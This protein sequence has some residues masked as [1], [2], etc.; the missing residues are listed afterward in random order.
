M[1][2]IPRKKSPRAPSLPLNEALERAIK[3]YDRE[4]LHP[5]TTDIIAQHLGYKSANNGSALSILASLRYFGLLDRP[6]EGML[7]VAK[8]VESYKFAPDA[9]L[10]RSLLLGFL[11]RPALYSDL[12]EKY[13]SG[14]PSDANLKY[15]L[16]QRGFA[17]QAAESALTVFKGS[18]GFANYFG[19]ESD[20]EFEGDTGDDFQDPITEP[21]E[22]Q[23]VAENVVPAISSLPLPNKISQEDADLD[24]I[25]VRLPGGRRAWL[26]IP[27]PFYN[28]DKARLKAQIDLLLTLEDEEG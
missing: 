6:K 19:S 27:T 1:T 10:R 17:P 20:N 9:N 5:A 18:V 16:I 8:E 11:G 22:A 24:R 15:E 23:P 26:L 3:I 4:R 28:A 12:L 2:G 7:S 25:P 13:A 14:L 21:E